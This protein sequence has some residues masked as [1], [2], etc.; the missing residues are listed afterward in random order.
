[1]EVGGLQLSDIA[2]DCFD[3]LR[4]AKDFI[5]HLIEEQSRVLRLNPLPRET[6]RVNP[7]VFRYAGRP[8]SRYRCLFCDETVVLTE[9]TTRTSLCHMSILP[10]YFTCVCNVCLEGMYAI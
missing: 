9:T 6:D 4:K 7:S 5:D 2:K 1:M 10:A 8:G 3:A